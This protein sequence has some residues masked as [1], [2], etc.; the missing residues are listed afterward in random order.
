MKAA[1]MKVSAL[2]NGYN[3]KWK[4]IKLTGQCKFVK[5]GPH[6]ELK[7]YQIEKKFLGVIKFKRWVLESD[8]Y[9]FPEERVIVGKCEEMI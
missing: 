3:F 5:G 7:Y 6:G 1:Y 2:F 8:V 9:F 4:K